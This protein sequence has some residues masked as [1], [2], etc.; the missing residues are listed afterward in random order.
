MTYFENMEKSSGMWD[1]TK[2]VPVKMEEAC[3]QTPGQARDHVK[4]VLGGPPYSYYLEEM[5][6]EDISDLN[7]MTESDIREAG[8]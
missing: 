2:P 1:E 8:Y 4:E 7:L 5:G 6:V 3:F